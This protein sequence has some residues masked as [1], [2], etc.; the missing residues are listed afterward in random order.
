M[1][2]NIVLVALISFMFVIGLQVAEPA[3]AASLKVI[4]HGSY[5]NLG[6]NNYD[7]YKWTAYKKGENYVVMKGSYYPETNLYKA[8]FYMYFQKISKTKIKTIEKSFVKNKKTGKTK[9][10]SQKISYHKTKLTAVQY[11]WRSI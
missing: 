11:Y 10:L 9:I 8:Y 2:K 6:D 5:N 3:A 4:D 1:G 7:T